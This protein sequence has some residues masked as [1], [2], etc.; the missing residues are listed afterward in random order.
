[1]REI[2]RYIRAFSRYLPSRITE[3]ILQ[4]PDRIHLEGEKR[5]VTVLFGDLSGF[6]SLTEKLEDP[7]KIVEI[8]NRYFVRML[9]I[10]EKYGGDVDKFLGDAIMVIFGAPVAHKDDPERAVRAALEMIEA[11]KE[12]GVVHT[13]KG[14]VQVNM[15]IGINTGEVV[16][17]NMGSDRRMEYTVM[18]DN[19]NLSA[20]LEAV[21][22]AGEVIISDRTYRYVKDVF[23][24]DKLQPVK[25]KGKEKPI[26][27][28]RVRG[29]K[30]KSEKSYTFFDREEETKVIK[31][32]VSRSIQGKGNFLNIFGESG[33]GK[34][35][36]ILKALKDRKGF[37]FFHIKGDRFLKNVPFSS[38]KNFLTEEYRSNIPD[39][40]KFLFEKDP[41]EEI[42]DVNKRFRTFIENTLKI[43]PLVVFLEDFESVDRPTLNLFYRLEVKNRP[44]LLILESELP[45]ESWNNYHIKGVKK[46]TLRKILQDRT[47]MLVQDN[48]VEYIHKR[49][50]GNPFFALQ[51]FNL[52]IE[53]GYIQKIAGEIQCTGKP[54]DEFSLPEDFTALI[55]QR[56]DRLP[57]KTYQVLQYGSILGEGF[58]EKLINAI[59]NLPMS[60]VREGILE[61][62]GYGFLKSD[63]TKYSFT[64]RLIK[65][66][67]YSTLFKRRREEL[68]LLAG[69][70]LE[71][72]YAGRKE[73]HPYILAYHFENG[74]DLKK[75]I[76]Y[77]LITAKRVKN[78]SS[79]SFALEILEHAEKLLKK[80][81]MPERMLDILMEKAEVL[82]LT[83]ELEMGKRTA[84]RAMLWAGKIN[85]I[86]LAH[87]LV[88]LASLYF[89]QGRIKSAER[90]Y[91]RALKLY[92]E[93]G[94]KDG[95]IAVY[96]NLG[97]LFLQTSKFKNAVQHFNRA[98]NLGLS[99]GR[100]DV[101]AISYFN[102]GYIYDIMGNLNNARE[103]YEKSLDI[104]KSL[105][106][107]AWQARI[108]TNL[109]AMFVAHG[110][111]TSGEINLDR[112]IK[113][114]EQVGDEEYWSRAMLNK[115][116]IEFNRGN[117]EL[118]L[119][120]YKKSLK[121]FKEKGF[122]NEVNILLTNIAEVWEKKG[123]LTL[124]EK[125][126]LKALE[127]TK[128][129]GDAYTGTY[130]FLKLGQVNL[131][132]ANLTKAKEWFQKAYNT[133]SMINAGD[134][135]S[136]AK[137]FEARIHIEQENLDE[138]I[139][140]I[141]EIDIEGIGDPEIKGRVLETMGR[142]Y[143]LEG[144]S[145]E[146]LTIAQRL[147]KGGE[148]LSIPQMK[149]NGLLLRIQALK[150]TG[151]DYSE[152]VWSLNEILNKI[153]EVYIRL[154]SLRMLG[155][156]YL[157]LGDM[158]SGL[159]LLNMAL[160][161]SRDMGIYIHYFRTINTLT[162][163]FLRVKN[164][165]RVLEL[166][167]EFIHHLKTKLKEDAHLLETSLIKDVIAKNLDIL[168][169]RE[170]IPLAVEFLRGLPSDYVK[171]ISSLLSAEEET[172][173]KLLD[174]LDI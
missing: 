89:K 52:L 82:F 70:F 43:S 62:I 101:V 134:L 27:I 165:D 161:S 61:A 48:I 8:V 25:V 45:V 74:G 95:E 64:S 29:I 5:F 30:K 76:D 123:E 92:K 72:V 120:I 102:M 7:E 145:E 126:Y 63:G 51:I 28:Y 46:E 67:I 166:G 42:R 124:A 135:I 81:R 168:L 75:A 33:V 147:I 84:R 105:K 106:N 6:T 79:F 113:L 143:L 112:A 21:A 47:G 13:P 138:A 151:M 133:A 71:E 150:N 73:E 99:T 86:K 109:G 152:D 85:Q 164:L 77:Y 146:T 78:L 141:E 125:N 93:N 16:A 55:I 14:D 36:L 19:V 154:E 127:G 83:G 116:V 20:R 68:H 104:W 10:V 118:A 12:L 41:N 23:E 59:F 32:Y 44:I 128:K 140:V 110:D 65:D 122:Q 18:G 114:A 107:V 172:L 57:E 137:Q 167:E 156:I 69:K 139:K 66:A 37:R 9:E 157:E 1:M 121:F 130:I 131:W 90:Y 80:E 160:S 60:K 170:N 50:E 149:A 136:D 88:T 24:F 163:Y 153:D 162:Q 98:I 22:N 39:L 91:H 2:E 3:K 115:G 34:T 155:E 144:K 4:D 35:S 174:N 142:A 58:D 119:D 96:T 49:S 129:I 158:T 132:K 159:D 171:K 148:I 173:K 87:I 103:Y 54:L 111:Y 17:L 38:L 31:A 40:L 169:K 15:S 53:K 94:S 117:L 108:Y 26:Q 97:N 11:I 56:L 100:L